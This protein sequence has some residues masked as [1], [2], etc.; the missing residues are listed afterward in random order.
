MTAFNPLA[1]QRCVTQ[2]QEFSSSVCQ[3]VA[4]V[5]QASRKHLPVM[6]ERMGQFVYSGGCIKN[7]IYAPKLVGLMV[8]L[9]RVEWLGPRFVFSIL[10]VQSFW[11]LEG[12]KPSDEL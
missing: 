12:F 11:K 1:A 2:G 10:L 5:T 3:A 6:L 9:F 4:G 8:L 7:A